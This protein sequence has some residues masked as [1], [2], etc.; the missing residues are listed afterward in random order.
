MSESATAEIIPFPAR[1]VPPAPVPRRKAEDERLALALANLN[2][3][4][5]KQRAAM[6]AWKAS[7]IDLRAETERL[8][9][10]LRRYNQSLSLLDTQV[11]A[12]RAQAKKL[13]SWAA[14]AL[15]PSA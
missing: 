14:G 4:L 1:P 15:T 2:D 13:E 10:S 5:T 7:L 6:A 12:L 11:G 8:G 3:A 9:A